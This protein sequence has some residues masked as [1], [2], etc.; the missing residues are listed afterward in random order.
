M[1]YHRRRRQ[2]QFYSKPNSCVVSQLA[3]VCWRAPQPAQGSTSRN[4]PILIEPLH[5]SSSCAKP[6]STP[7]STTPAQVR[8]EDPRQAHRAPASLRLEFVELPVE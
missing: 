4:A 7:A 2:L 3:R 5:W 1:R 6:A 8:L